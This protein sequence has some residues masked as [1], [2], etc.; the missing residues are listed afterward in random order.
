MPR[1]LLFTVALLVGLS[2]CTVDEQALVPATVDEDPSLPAIDID[3]TRVHAE[4]FGDPQKPLVVFLHGGPGADYR[5]MLPLRAIADDGYHVV[6][7]DHR[8]AGL[9]RRYSDCEAFAGDAYLHD[10]EAVIDHYAV[11][12]TAP[13]ALV[14]HSWGAMYATWYVDRHPERVRSVVLAEPGAFTRPE[15]DEYMSRLM[16]IGVFS[17]EFEDASAA[18]RI[19]TPDDH[20]REDFLVL[21]SSRILDDK[22][23][24]DPNRPEPKWRYGAAAQR[25]SL[26]VAGDF[27][28][29]THLASYRGRA[30]FV[31]GERNRVH[32][33]EQQTSLAAHYPNARLVTLNGVGHDM[34][35]NAFD[36]S[37][38]LIR[39]EL[40]AAFAG[41][42][43]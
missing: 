6:F 17:A 28:W 3:G 42:A 14:G 40:S 15:L 2:C 27:D 29:T 31:H 7:F 43:S 34:F 18:R 12:S 24:V 37:L 13:I 1:K 32:T 19:L 4:S 30:L 16:K 11:S 33:L 36:A 25:C 10:L 21:L 22:L 9:S 8:G 39:G 20:A 26:K 23:G 38:T 41:G 5:S 35:Y